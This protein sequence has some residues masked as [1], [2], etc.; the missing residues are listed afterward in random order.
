M[1]SQRLPW[2]VLAVLLCWLPLVATAGQDSDNNTAGGLNASQDLR[3]RVVI[4]QIIYFR[5]GS[6]T[7]SDVDK[8]EFQVNPGAGIGNDQSYAGAVP[9]ALGN[10]TPIAATGGGALQVEI[11]SN[12]GTVNLS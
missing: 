9:P 8:V 5:I 11:Q 3:H 2:R 12:V 6:A 7:F 1:A 10:G 4:P